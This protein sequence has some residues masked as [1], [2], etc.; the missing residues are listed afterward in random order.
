[1][2]AGN[3]TTS[4]KTCGWAIISTAQIADKVFPALQTA[5]N[6]KVVAIASR[7]KERAEG[8]AKSHGL[9]A[10]AGCTYDEV[11]QRDDVRKL[12]RI[13]AEVPCS[14]SFLHSPNRLMLCTCLYQVACEMS[15]S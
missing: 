14:H 4:G 5:S 8:W 7:S 9:D 10:G 13:N 15:S 3:P 2:C 11:L 6:S 12:G 1:V